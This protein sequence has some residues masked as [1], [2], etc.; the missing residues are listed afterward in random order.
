MFAVYSPEDILNK[1][2]YNT[3]DVNL[4]IQSIMHLVIWA[5]VSS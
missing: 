5:L 1:A 4:F 2:T 3:T